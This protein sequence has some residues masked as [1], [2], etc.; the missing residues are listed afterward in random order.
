MSEGERTV[1]W[2]C[3]HCGEVESLPA[4]KQPKGW[5][6]VYAVFPPRADPSDRGHH[7][8]KDLC[9][10]CSKPLSDFIFAR[11]APHD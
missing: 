9:G 5:H 10:E 7:V 3:D 6:R 8:V 2:T 11:E 1:A 4:D